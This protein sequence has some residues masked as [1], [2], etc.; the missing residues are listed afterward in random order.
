MTFGSNQVVA[1][2][3]TLKINGEA[4]NDD[5]STVQNGKNLLDYIKL[6]LKSTIEKTICLFFKE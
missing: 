4:I 2:G 5:E 1:K 6:I 3:R